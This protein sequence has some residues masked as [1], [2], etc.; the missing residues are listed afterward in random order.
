MVFIIKDKNQPF[1]MFKWALMNGKPLNVTTN[2][3][4]IDG[5]QV[6]NGNTHIAPH[7]SFTAIQR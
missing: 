4:K 6:F 2:K 7:I 1:Q 3:S 5:T